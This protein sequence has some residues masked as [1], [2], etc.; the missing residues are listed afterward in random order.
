MSPREA[1]ASIFT[2]SLTE[3]GLVHS[4][5]FIFW[6][7]DPKLNLC[8]LCSLAQAHQDLVGCN[9]QF[10]HAQAGGVED[11]IRE[12]A[13][14]GDDAAFRDA[15]DGFTFVV[16]VDERHELGHLE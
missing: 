9:R 2:A 13:D 6:S 7:S 10:A 1:S 8:H 14:S 12:R 16:V 4:N 3:V 5:A 11:G 15:D